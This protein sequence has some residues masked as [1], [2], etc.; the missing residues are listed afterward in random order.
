MNTIDNF[1]IISLLI[2]LIFLATSLS[3][4]K[5]IGVVG[6]I[7][8]LLLGIWV[9]SDNLYYKIGITG[10][11]YQTNSVSYDNSTNVTT[12]GNIVF[13]NESTVNQYQEIQVPSVAGTA[14]VKAKDILGL[15]L[16]LLGIYATMYY[17]M[18]IFG[19]QRQ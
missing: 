2:L 3:N 9:L 10:V 11:K 13:V 16:L 17:A 1:L 7:L 18:G 12:M 6:A 8:L 4:I 5:I 19:N 14:G 15:T